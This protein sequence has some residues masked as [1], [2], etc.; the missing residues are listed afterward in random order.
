LF[1]CAD[2]FEESLASSLTDRLSGSMATAENVPC[3][4]RRRLRQWAWA[5]VVLLAGL[6]AIWLGS[7]VVPRHGYF[8]R[9][10]LVTGV[11]VSPE[12]PQAGGFVSQAVRITGSTGMIVDL[13]VLR[14]AEVT[15]PLPLVVML[16]GHRT[17]RDAVDAIGDPGAMVVA[18]L[19][20][21]YRGSENIRGVVQSVASI[22]AIQRALLDTPPAVSVALDWLQGRPWVDPT[23]VELMGLSLG[24][25]FAAV[26]GALDTRFRRVWLIHGRVGNREWIDNRLEPQVANRALRRAAAW[27]VHLLAHGS[28]FKTEDWV[29]KIAPRRVI[30]IGATEDEQMPRSSVDQLFRAAREPREILWSNG[31]HVRPK[32]QQIVQQLLAMVRSRI[33]EKETAVKADL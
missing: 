10:G 33:E 5:A 12:I 23:R 31:G 25:P 17:G 27:L 3:T 26:A 15:K 16:G 20:Y 14:P 4:T 13:R 30:V 1:S 2:V 24:V 32:H 22:P 7:H 18:A 29:P 21:P 11:E 9:R 28:S 8:S 6:P 19:D